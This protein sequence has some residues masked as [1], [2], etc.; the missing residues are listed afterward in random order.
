MGADFMGVDF[1]GVD[2]VGGHPTGQI[3]GN[4]TEQFVYASTTQIM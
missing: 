3:V 1:M 2:L 4:I